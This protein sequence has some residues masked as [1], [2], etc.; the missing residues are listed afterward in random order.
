MVLVLVPGLAGVRDEQLRTVQLRPAVA[1]VRVLTVLPYFLE[2]K[3][4]SILYAYA[5]MQ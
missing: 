2:K 4:E 1:L 3:R 5:A